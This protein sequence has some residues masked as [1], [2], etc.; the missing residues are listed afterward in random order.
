MGF[1]LLLPA[2]MSALLVQD[3]SQTT[4]NGN[5]WTHTR[6]GV[7]GP[8]VTRALQITT[9]GRLIVR[10]TNSDQITYK[11]VE[12]VKARSLAGAHQLFGSTTMTNKVVN[13]VTMLAIQ[14]GAHSSVA[15]ELTIEVP[16]R[17][18]SVFLDVRSGDIEASELDGNLRA[19]TMAG[20]IRCDK[21]R[22][23][24]EGKTG[25]GEIHLGKI[26]GAIRCANSAGSIIIDNAGSSANCQTAGGEIQ[27]GEAFGELVLSTE[28]GNIQ[29]DRAGSNLE[30]HTGEGVIEIGQCK[31]MVYA[32]TRG[33]SIQVGSARGVRC[34][35]GAG[36]VRVKTASGPMQIQTALG[37]ILAELL[38]GSRLEDSSLVAGTGDIT[39]L[40]PSNLALSVLARNDSGA[41]PR[42]VSDFSELRRS[43]APSKPAVVF[44]NAMVYQGSI[45]GGGPL[46]KLNTAGGIIYVR[47]SK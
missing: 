11:L 46:L 23:S 6:S 30:A 13:G 35:S 40:I 26:G 2:V 16:R 31:G 39:V 42:I 21:I 33:G 44:Q 34:Q 25:G 19:D 22:G 17:M 28:G 4:N 10:G 29:V 37:S 1:C 24:F 12:R 45:N 36:Q 20:Q 8:T 15:T 38:A 43:I 7:A 32:D 41:N 3:V 9:R 5:D 18:A 14:L 27:I 47:K